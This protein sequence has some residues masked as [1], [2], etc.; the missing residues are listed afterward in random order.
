M[1]LFYFASCFSRM[2]RYRCSSIYIFYSL[3]MLQHH[4]NNRPGQKWEVEHY[5][6]HLL[7]NWRYINV[8]RRANV[9]HSNV[10]LQNLAAARIITESPVSAF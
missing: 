5:L 9:R 7:T 1:L 2:C 8:G 6:V 10:D 4:L 3:H